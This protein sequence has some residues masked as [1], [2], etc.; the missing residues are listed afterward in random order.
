MQKVTIQQEKECRSDI[1]C[2][3]GTGHVSGARSRQCM[4]HE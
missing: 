4:W 1:H 2:S 3:E